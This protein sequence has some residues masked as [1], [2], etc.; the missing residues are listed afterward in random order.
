MQKSGQQD[1][2]NVLLETLHAANC[3]EVEFNKR[4]ESL[5]SDANKLRKEKASLEK[6]VK[7]LTDEVK[8]VKR[9]S[10]E[11]IA[12]VSDLIPSDEYVNT[13]VREFFERYG[14]DAVL[15]DSTIV[16]KL[17]VVENMHYGVNLTPLR[18]KTTDGKK[19]YR[20]ATFLNNRCLHV[21]KHGYP[22]GGKTLDSVEQAHENITELKNVLPDFFNEED[23]KKMIEQ[24]KKP[25]DDF[26]SMLK[27]VI[28][29]L[30][31]S[32]SDEEDEEDDSTENTEGGETQDR[33]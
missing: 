13:V 24:G 23:S 9:M 27:S 33:D 32:Y 18:N 10:D 15:K 14:S 30:S 22:C 12:H 28:S 26:M 25:N 1:T 29:Q 2:L 8:Y 20:L 4:I 3:R 6:D 17:G 11:R 21:E 31:T 19:Q 7:Y 16:V 5:T